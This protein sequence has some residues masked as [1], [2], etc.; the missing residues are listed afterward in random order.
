MHYDVKTTTG[1]EWAS[2]HATAA[3][4]LAGWYIRPTVYGST[5]WPVACIGWLAVMVCGVTEGSQRELDYDDVYNQAGPT[6]CTVYCG[7]IQNNLT[8]SH[9]TLHYVHWINTPPYLYWSSSHLPLWLGVQTYLIVIENSFI[10]EFLQTEEGCERFGILCQREVVDNAW[11]SSVDRVW[12]F[13]SPCIAVHFRLALLTE[14]LHYLL[15]L[16]T[17]HGPIVVPI[18]WQIVYFA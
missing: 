11:V 4:Q 15:L 18:F 3:S 5:D 2:Q 7:G 6:N 17:V 10:E 16:V 8:G 1:L 14:L 13:C 9:T 12:K